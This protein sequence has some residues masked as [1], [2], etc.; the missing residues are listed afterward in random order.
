MIRN[1]IKRQITIRYETKNQHEINK[2]TQRLDK[3]NNDVTEKVRGPDSNPDT[4]WTRGPTN[5]KSN[6]VTWTKRGV[7]NDIF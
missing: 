1:D 7:Y 6:T 4:K 3:I 2:M 5:T